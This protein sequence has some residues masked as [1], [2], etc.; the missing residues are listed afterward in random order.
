M[1]FYH[2]LIYVILLLISVRCTK[3]PVDPVTNL[4]PE[5]M[6]VV[7]IYCSPEGIY[8]PVPNVPTYYPLFISSISGNIFSD[9]I[10]EVYAVT[11]LDTVGDLESFYQRIE[12][13]ASVVFGQYMGI[14]DPPSTVNCRIE[15]SVG[16]FSGVENIPGK[17]SSFRIM[18]GDKI[19][20]GD[21]LTIGWNAENT[22]FFNAGL[23]IHY[24][25]T[26]GWTNYSIDTLLFQESITLP[27]ALLSG[28]FESSS[29]DVFCSIVQYNGPLPL[30]GSQCNMIEENKGYLFC[31]L[32]WTSFEFE[33]LNDGT[34]TKID[35][36][37][38]DNYQI[39]VTAVNQKIMHR[40]IGNS[41]SG[42]N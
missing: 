28:V 32:A 8:Y 17:I 41:N 11:V 33:I 21:S 37:L 2:L 38:L 15:T 24:N 16:T 1:K 13:D 30:I 5:P 19:S 31:E 3:D 22:A 18:N 40:L 7:F 23:Y 12:D 34:I 29:T 6:A 35:S 9:P 42:K 27:P 36:S 4:H 10:A 14:Y 20:R 26:S 39:D 25:N